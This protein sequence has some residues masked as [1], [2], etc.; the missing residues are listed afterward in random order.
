[1]NNAVHKFLLNY[2]IN[3]LLIR[4]KSLWRW[5]IYKIMFLDVIHRPVFLFKT[6]RPEISVYRL[7]QLSRFLLEDGDRIQFPKHYV[8]N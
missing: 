5:Y 4:S 3:S 6:Q 2:S 7:D 8:L 1:M